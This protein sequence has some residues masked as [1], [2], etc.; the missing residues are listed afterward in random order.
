LWGQNEYVRPRG[1]QY[2]NNRRLGF[3]VQMIKKGRDKCAINKKIA[4]QIQLYFLSWSDLQCKSK[5][6]FRKRLNRRHMTNNPTV[7]TPPSTVGSER[8]LDML[9]SSM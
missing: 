9:F 7:I 5:R 1:A 3:Y 2:S 4:L 6:E 8:Y